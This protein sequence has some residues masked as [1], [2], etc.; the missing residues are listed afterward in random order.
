MPVQAVNSGSQGNVL[1]NSITVLSTPSPTWTPS[2]TRQPSSTASDAEIGPRLRTRF[3]LYIA[4]LSKGTKT[5]VDYAVRSV[6]QGLTD[7]ITENQDYDGYQH[8]GT[9]CV[10]VDD[11]TGY[12]SSA[13]LTNVFNAIDA[14]RPLTIPFAVYPPQVLTAAVSMSLTT[15]A[16][17]THGSV[18]S[19]VSSALAA[20]INA[21]PLGQSL[22][23]TKLAAIA[24]AVPG[25][26]NASGILLNGG[27]SDLMANKKQK[28]LAGSL[29]IS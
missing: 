29:S 8:Y 16:N 4:S 25:V 15:A 5:A 2:P 7:T 14:I 19:A 22:P 17:Y 3:F 20:F 12:P 6:Q 1:A 13:L 18:V 26:S 28:I 11:G 9:F 27:T 24:Y 21:I 23:Y 10:V